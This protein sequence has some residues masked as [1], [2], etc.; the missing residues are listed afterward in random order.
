MKEEVAGRGRGAFLAGA[1][2]QTDK[3][4]ATGEK[5]TNLLNSHV[6]TE[7]FPREWRPKE[8][9]RAGSFCIIF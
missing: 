7:T 5:Q 4:R 3:D 9:V 2:N 8:L 1:E 6:Y